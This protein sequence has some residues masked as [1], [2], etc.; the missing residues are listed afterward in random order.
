MSPKDL[1][2]RLVELETLVTH[3]QR[4]LEELSSVFVEQ[5]KTQTDLQRRLTNLELKLSRCLDSDNAEGFT[6]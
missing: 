1:E 6:S 5:D 2:S 4:N 3:S